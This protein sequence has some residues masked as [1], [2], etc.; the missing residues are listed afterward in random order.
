M[1]NRGG[2]FWHKGEVVGPFDI[3]FGQIRRLH[4]EDYCIDLDEDR[5][6]ARYGKFNARGWISV[7]L[8]EFPKEFRMNLLLL[9]VA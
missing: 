1:R 9:G 4:A 3:Y 7:P 6:E 5:L 2:Y 8:E